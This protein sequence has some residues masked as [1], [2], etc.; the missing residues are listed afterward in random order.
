MRRISNGINKEKWTDW[1]T[2]R[3]MS[4]KFLLIARATINSKEEIS[5]KNEVALGDVADFH[6]DSIFK[7]ISLK[8]KKIGISNPWNISMP[9]IRSTQFDQTLNRWMRN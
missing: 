9:L 2:G 7:L 8:V 5:A 6:W 4:I 3:V 1:V